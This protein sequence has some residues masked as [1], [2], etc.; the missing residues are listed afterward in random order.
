MNN[1]QNSGMVWKENTHKSTITH[2]RAN[3]TKEE[4]TQGAS[5][6]VNQNQNTQIKTQIKP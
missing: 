3:K 6:N 2:A 1:E 4:E 5:T